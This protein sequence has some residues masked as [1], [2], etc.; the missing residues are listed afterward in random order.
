MNVK[1]IKL[2]KYLISKMLL[3]IDSIVINDLK[4]LNTLGSFSWEG[5]N[6]SEFISLLQLFDN[7]NNLGA[8]DGVDDKHTFVFN[9]STDVVE[10]DM[11][12]VLQKDDNPVFIDIETKNGTDVDLE[13]KLIEQLNKRKD[14]QIQQIIK[15]NRFIVAGFVN[16]KYV[17]GYHYDGESINELEKE[18]AFIGLVQQLT[19]FDNDDDFLIQTSNLAAI[20]KVC[21]SIK[22]NRYKYYEDTNR[23]FEEITKVINDVDVCVIYGNAG[24][25]KSILALKTFFEMENTKLLLLNSKLY[26]ALDFHK[27]YQ[28]E[29]AFFNSAAFLNSINEDT[30]SIV[31]EC[32]RMSF[33]EL[34]KVIQ[35]SKVTIIFGDNRQAFKK[36]SILY[37]PKVLEQKLKDEGFNVF[38]RIMKKARRYS[39]E[40]DQAIS[41]LTRNEGNIVKLPKDY[42]IN[43]YYD[44]GSFLN[45]YDSLEG[46]KKIYVPCIYSKQTL[47]IYDREFI[48]AV[49]TD[50]SFS[51]WPSISNYYGVTYHALSF[52]IDH[53]FV[54]LRGIKLVSFGKKN[55]IFYRDLSDH[56]DYSDIQLFLNELNILFTRGRK[57]LNIYVDDIRVFL[58]LN[59]IIKKIK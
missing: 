48:K 11:V 6:K 21:Q 24:T 55:Y 50:D 44:E 35:K 54:F 57:T 43:L 53:A 37:S 15:N 14:D 23:L 30:I 38:K 8:F 59:S 22:E 52:D 2:N 10:M 13:D 7:L 39:D 33:S 45:R 26:F 9:Y 17:K 19:N 16:N 46:I 40:V 56:D 28:K 25:G 27:Y 3:S 5:F 42:S 32:Q 29:K 1:G 34:V 51:I 4:G 20:N 47:T 12:T 31:D 58:Y 18:T 49:Y 41:L 36:G